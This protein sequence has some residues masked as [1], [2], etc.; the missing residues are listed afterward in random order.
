MRTQF[1]EM[2]GRYAI[3][4]KYISKIRWT[5]DLMDRFNVLYKRS[6]LSLRKIGDAAEVGHSYVDKLR[7]GGEEGK[8]FDA[9]YDAV[10][11]VLGAIG[12]KEYDLFDCPYISVN[13]VQ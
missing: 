13:Q 10:L 8:E 6:G 11:R 5:R 9:D 12:V 7:K 2:N 4:P 3:D 1:I